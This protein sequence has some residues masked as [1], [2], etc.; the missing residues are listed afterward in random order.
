MKLEFKC[1]RC[2]DTDLYLVE[3]S[4]TATRLGWHDDSTYF[5]LGK[6]NVIDCDS[7]RLECEDGHPLTFK[8]GNEVCDFDD[9]EKWCKEQ[10][11]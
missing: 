10:S 3:T 11:S 5:A 9:F 2:G 1:P 4:K 6:E 7:S 8:N